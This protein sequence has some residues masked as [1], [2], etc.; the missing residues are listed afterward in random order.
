MILIN[1]HPSYYIKEIMEEHDINREVMASR[2]DMDLSVFDDF[3]KGNIDV[4]IDLA[5]KLAYTFNSS[6]KLWLNLQRK[7][8]G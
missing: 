5:N 4:D 7:Y 2:L 8:D 1:F 6:I 3:I